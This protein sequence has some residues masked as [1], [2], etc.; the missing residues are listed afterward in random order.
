MRRQIS[1]RIDLISTMAGQNTQAEN[2]E[3]KITQS[4]KIEMTT[5]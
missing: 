5:N 1:H 2:T 4:P 3:T